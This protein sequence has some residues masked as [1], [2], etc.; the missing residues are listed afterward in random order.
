AD[1]LRQLPQ[2]S[3]LF[4]TDAQGLE[5]NSSNFWPVPPVDLSDRE[6]F[7]DA[8]TADGHAP[9]VSAPVKSRTTGRWTFFITR[10]VES[11]D[12]VFLGTI[13]AALEL[14]HFEKFYQ[15]ITLLEG[16]SV[17]IIRSDGLLLVRY[18]RIEAMIGTYLPKSSHWYEA[19]AKGGGTFRTPG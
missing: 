9:L 8:L 13:Q 12:G 7:R 17:A 10:R 16:A 4:L 5:I 18:P 19:V 6:F 11:R 1:R 3:A 2:A 14:R 15:T